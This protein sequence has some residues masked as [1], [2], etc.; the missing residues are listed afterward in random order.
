M[1]NVFEFRDNLIEEYSSF[2]R[3]FTRIA[4]PDIF[5]EVDR[6]YNRGR[7]WPDPLIQINPNYR[8][9]ETIQALV[10]QGLLHRACAGIFMAG[11]ADGHPAPPSSYSRT[12]TA[13]ITC[14]FTKPR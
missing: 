13:A 8:R 1:Q 12:M 2:S 6:Q 11:K 9:G 7:Y 14:L 3:S 5:D 4:A 10:R